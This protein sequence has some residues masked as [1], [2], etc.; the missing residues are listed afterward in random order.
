MPD[1]SD[2]TTIM[3]QRLRPHTSQPS[4][5]VS[6][7]HTP[8]HTR[9]SH[10]HTSPPSTHVSAI[11]TRLSRHPFPSPFCAQAFPTTP[12]ACSTSP[13]GQAACNSVSARSALSST[14]CW[15]ATTLIF[16]VGATPCVS[17]AQCYVDGG[18]WRWMLAGGRPRRHLGACCRVF[19]LGATLMEG[20]GGGCMPEGGHADTWAGATLMGSTGGGCMQ[21]GLPRQRPG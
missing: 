4:T 8:I 5:H 3:Q 7:I 15:K 10:P 2:W 14:A 9:L 13:T 1:K 12:C 17:Q 16:W 18:H 20:T 11:H 21:E 6:A 19:G